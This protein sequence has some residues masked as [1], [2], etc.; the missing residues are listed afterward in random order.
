VLVATIAVAG[1]LGYL[2]GWATTL[3]WWIGTL[4]VIGMLVASRLLVAQAGAKAALLGSGIGIA[5]LSV[6]SIADQLNLHTGVAPAVGH[7]DRVVIT[8]IA[9]VVVL[10][11]SA[12][13]AGIASAL[14]RRVEFWVA[15]A[16]SAV[17]IPLA[18]LL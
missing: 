15:G 2:T 9:A 6:G 10:L 17:S 8:A 4:V 18:T 1:A 11:G 14:D 5:L 3:T 13:P 7:A 12:I 16:A